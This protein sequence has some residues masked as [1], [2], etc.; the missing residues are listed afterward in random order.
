MNME[1]K[2]DIRFIMKSKI[3]FYT[4]FLE[5]PLTRFKQF[6]NCGFGEISSQRSTTF[7]YIWNW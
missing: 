1:Y 7:S 2:E 5:Y 3:H 4:H 6:P